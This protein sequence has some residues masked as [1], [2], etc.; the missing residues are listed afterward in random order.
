MSQVL[1]SLA[2]G[3]LKRAK[4]I[5][6]A[7]RA[8]HNRAA[9]IHR[10]PD[11]LLQYIFTILLPRT[12]SLYHSVHMYNKFRRSVCMCCRHWAELVHNTPEAWSSLACT[13]G[14]PKFSLNYLKLALERSR[15]AQLYIQIMF[16][17]DDGS[18]AVMNFMAVLHPVL[19]RCYGLDIYVSQL[20]HLMVFDT[21]PAI[22]QLSLTFGQEDPEQARTLALVFTLPSISPFSLCVDDTPLLHNDEPFISSLLLDRM[23]PSNLTSLELRV[24]CTSDQLY[25]MLR[26]CSKLRSADILLTDPQPI[27]AGVQLDHLVSLTL[28]GNLGS[29]PHPFHAP[30]L[31][32]LTIGCNIQSTSFH[33]AT[34]LKTL[35]IYPKLR[36]L[37]IEHTAEGN[38]MLLSIVRDTKSL[39]DLSIWR[40]HHSTAAIPRLFAGILDQLN[41][42]CLEAHDKGSRPLRRLN[43]EGYMDVSEESTVGASLRGVLVRA[44]ELI[45]TTWMYNWGARESDWRRNM[46]EQF[47][48]FRSVKYS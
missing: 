24:R 33:V 36:H 18:G 45:V 2:E 47:E 44:P 19:P 37:W 6:L 20:S 7:Q 27:P 26:S 41:N 10:L 23:D 39:E 22:K 28:D 9:P 48:N 15:T 8:R 29:M 40:R 42:Q 16:P 30:S 11:E 35:I 14:E 12:D 43:I 38:D 25:T 5:R 1:R 3:S 31:E 32:S 17:D 34:W 21:L 13:P 4:A 46:L